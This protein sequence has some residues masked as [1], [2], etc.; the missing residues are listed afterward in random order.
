MKWLFQQAKTVQGSK[1]KEQLQ[2]RSQ[3]LK[4]DVTTVASGGIK[5]TLQRMAKAHQVTTRTS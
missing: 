4:N 3:G 1:R 5:R 2:D